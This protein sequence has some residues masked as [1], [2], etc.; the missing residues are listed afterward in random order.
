MAKKNDNDVLKRAIKRWIRSTASLLIAI[1]IAITT[2]TPIAIF[3]GPII[4]SLD[5]ARRD[6]FVELG[7]TD[8]IAEFISDKIKGIKRWLYGD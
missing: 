8:S 6:G 5:K 1:L 3:L 2:G 4:E 7:I